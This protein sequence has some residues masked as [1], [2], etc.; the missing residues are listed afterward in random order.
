MAKARVFGSGLL[1]NLRPTQE[2][3]SDMS[4]VEIQISSCRSQITPDMPP[5]RWMLLP[6]T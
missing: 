5:S 2:L 1:E 4:A 3:V 6:V